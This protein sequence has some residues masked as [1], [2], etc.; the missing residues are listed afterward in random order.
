MTKEEI[1][2][3]VRRVRLG[4]QI[5]KVGASR[6]LRGSTGETRAE[7]AAEFV[8]GERPEPM[9]LREAVV[10]QCMLSREADLAAYR[11]AAVGGNLSPEQAREAMAAIQAGYARTLSE[12][13]QEI[14]S[15]ESR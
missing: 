3:L 13:L 7:F 15:Q 5:T 8:V 9:T 10:A 12:A 2:V 14:E 11:N 4:L 1:G 6:T